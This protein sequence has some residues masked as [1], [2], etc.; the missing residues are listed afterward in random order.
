M[1]SGSI[2][3]YNNPPEM[4]NEVIASALSESSLMKL[5]IVDNS[6]HGNILTY[7]PKDKRLEYIL[8]ERNVGFG[9]AHNI[10]IRKSMMG[11]YKYHV[12]LNP[13]IY[14][15]RGNLDR[16]Y[17]FMES[18]IEIG[19][20]MP[21]I[22][23]PDGSIQFLCKMNPTPFDLF[24]RRFAP[25]F[26][27]NFFKERMQK[28]EYRD[29]DYNKLMFDIPYLSGCFMLFRMEVLKKI[30]L[31]DE[32]I[33]MYIEDADITRRVLQVART[34]YF[35]EAVV[36]HHFAKGSHKNWRLMMYS[37]HGAIIYFN[38]WGWFSYK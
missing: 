21:Q 27:R 4:I 12:V 5:Y 18:N 34:A 32:R 35:P 23:Y 11:N 25:K 8:T 6:P 19:Q 10:A 2:V 3:L 7:L 30:G 1:I 37:I 17:N 28:Y 16:L 38:K 26:I 13:D 20:V 14:F 36:Y 33:F 29:K 24:A 15:S 31:F 22:L 9:A